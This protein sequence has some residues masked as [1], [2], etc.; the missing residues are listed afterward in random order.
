MPSEF[1]SQFGNA[2]ESSVLYSSVSHT[3]M[4]DDAFENTKNILA[5][6][7]EIERLVEVSYPFR[8]G[9]M[10]IYLLTAIVAFFANFF[11]L[12]ILA[13]GPRKNSQL[14]NFLSN[15][16]LSDIIF[17]IFNIMFTYITLVYNTWWLPE[18]LCPL[19]SFVQVLAPTVLF[20]T[21]IAIGIGRLVLFIF[22][23]FF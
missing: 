21:L 13:Y 16:G 12:L 2:T 4:F 19:S 7:R 1:Q 18:F 11:A 17:S 20:Y 15:L 3:T 23:N 9:M 14:N 22:L 6:P 5:N 8:T 10:V